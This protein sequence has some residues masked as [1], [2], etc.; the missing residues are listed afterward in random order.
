MMRDDDVLIGKRVMFVSSDDPYTRLTYGV[1]G[2]VTNI[3]C[4]GTVFVK[5]DN[6][7]TLGM[8]R[9]AGDRFLV[10]EEVRQ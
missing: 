7:S 1:E 3:D 5:W 2:T 4:M 6:G 9:D 8:V 10:I